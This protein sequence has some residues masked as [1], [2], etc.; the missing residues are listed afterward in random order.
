MATI[1]KRL[2]QLSSDLN[3]KGEVALKRPEIGKILSALAR[4]LLAA[5]LSRAEIFGGYTPFG[6]AI[7]AVSGP[8][9]TGF[10]GLLGVV[11]GSY[12]GGD[13]VWGLKYV[14]MS[15]LIYAAAFVFH[16]LRSYK[17]LW[18]KPTVAAFMA[19]ATG[20][21]YVQDTGWATPA[22]VFYITEI[23]LIGGS[24]YFFQIALLGL[25]KARTSEPQAGL[26]QT[27]S[28]LVLLCTCLIALRGVILPGGISVGRLFALFLIMST[29]YKNGLGS[30]SAT[31]AA[32]GIAMD[33]GGGGLPFFS[34]AYAFS[35]LFSGLFGKQGKI[36]FT[37]SFI[38]ANSVAVL[39]TWDM[40]LQVSAIYEVV[41]VSAL[42]LIL[43]GRL[44]EPY[45]IDLSE[46]DVPHE[47]EPSDPRGTRERIERMGKAFH[48][49]CESMRPGLVRAENDNDIAQIFDRAAEVCCRKCEQSNLCW[50]VDFEDTL[51]IM[52]N[53]SVPMRKRG[54]LKS[55]DFPEHFKEHCTHLNR[56]IDA[57]NAELR[58]LTMRRQFTSRL[59]ETQHTL[60]AQYADMGDMLE[61]LAFDLEEDIT[62]ETF[63]ER[64]LRRYLRTQDVAAKAA[65][66]RDR[67]GRLHAEIRGENLRP[68]LRG[69]DS[70]EKLSTVLGV[71]IMQ[72][73]A[74]NGKERL[75]IMEEEPL[76]AAVGIA[77]VRRRGQTVSGDRGSYFKAEDGCLYV[78]LTDGMGT[79]IEAAR[80]SKQI[81]E[82]LEA[83]LGAGLNPEIAMKLL[84]AALQTKNG[85]LTGCA[86]V[87]LLRLN[88]FTGQ[89]KFYKYGAAPTYIKR[90]KTLRV[91][92]GDSLAAG[93]KSGKIRGP[94]IAEQKINPGNFVV[95][96]SD[97]VT[98]EKDDKWLRTAITEHE[99]REAKELA[100][101]LLQ[102]AIDQAG[103]EDD[104][105]VLA[106][107]L[108]E[109]S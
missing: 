77:S 84:N 29:A 75:S 18:F 15:V 80:E 46:Y 45:A 54:A 40:T 38:L 55:E 26:K 58:A 50:T 41:I 51:N 91:V 28:M 99:G 85:D 102:I 48:T 23:A 107:Y 21:V 76:A 87:D 44:I 8:G 19:A 35:G 81:G 67:N 74:E 98:M 42:F 71:R 86:S 33:A 39:W 92:K 16:D 94:D 65:V 89:T 31:G 32:L 10:L 24:T 4:F 34:M 101:S 95:L 106:I 61:N 30:G 43:P 56:Y 103:C 60:C 97:G 64:K 52:N 68:L 12:L 90:G 53:A 82:A 108:E 62:R 2:S 11:L 79:G 105:T 78:I 27:I 14:A 73:E 13:F 3:L 88:L 36:L 93:L 63:R 109:R 20:F 83:F 9:I 66:F 25:G 70:L 57:V 49:L 69:K 6:V 47:T 96:V 7:V 5:G 72:K 17:R 37:A 59:R 104:M 1:R 100:R 22:L